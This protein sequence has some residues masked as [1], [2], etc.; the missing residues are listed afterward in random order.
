MPSRSLERDS[1]RLVA[2]VRGP[3]NFCRR[4]M[5]V[6]DDH[7]D[8]SPAELVVWRRTAAAAAF[9]ASFGSHDNLA[10][11][12]LRRRVGA[13]SK[14]CDSGVEKRPAPFAETKLLLDGLAEALGREE[15][16][17]AATTVFRF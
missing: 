10:L 2:T 8:A 6:V 12:A 15:S 17:I 13:I 14:R 16:P 3:R 11:L 5:E 7:W 1:E 4:A 9:L